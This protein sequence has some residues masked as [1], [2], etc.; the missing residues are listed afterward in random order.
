MAL[1]RV[2]Q[3]TS[4]ASIALFAALLACSDEGPQSAGFSTAGT[5]DTGSERTRS[6]SVTTS[7]NSGRSTSSG[8]GR[9]CSGLSGA[10][11]FSNPHPLGTVSSY[12][13]V[14]GCAPL[15]SGAGF[16]SRWFSFS[17]TS[18]A[19]SG[20]YAG[21]RF[22]IEGDESAVHPRLAAGAVTLVTSSSAGYWTDDGRWIPIAGLEPGSYM[23]GFE[24]LRSPL[25][26]LSTAAFDVVVSLR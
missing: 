11:S 2:Y 8:G 22:S 4:H 26:S 14:T 12:T 10:G 6:S 15:T 25:S 16:S 18:T 5:V 24:K 9:S 20:A 3:L 17:I 21:A 1:S 19:P 13:E 7:S 23:L